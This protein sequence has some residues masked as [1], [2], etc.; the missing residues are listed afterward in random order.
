MSVLS[1][2]VRGVRDVRDAVANAVAERPRDDRSTDVAEHARHGV[3]GA[4]AG[5]CTRPGKW[6]N[7]T[8]PC[9][10]AGV[11]GLGFGRPSLSLANPEH[12]KTGCAGR[13]T[14]SHAIPSFRAPRALPP[15]GGSVILRVVDRAVLARKRN[16]A[17][18]RIV[19]LN[20]LVVTRTSE[21]VGGR[22]CTVL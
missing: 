10:C 17:H 13:R 16:G 11:G 15:D 14:P 8:G 1:D 20:L 9:D 2:V 6:G 18:S 5:V 4:D 22:E 12:T 7:W 3:R 19:A 21:T